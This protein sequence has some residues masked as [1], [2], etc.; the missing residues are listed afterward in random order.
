MI[1]IP[2]FALT[3]P[4]PLKNGVIVPRIIALIVSICETVVVVVV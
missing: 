4:L 2:T 1:M 3:L